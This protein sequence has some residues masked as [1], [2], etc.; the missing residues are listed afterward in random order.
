M[1]SKKKLVISLS[2]AAAVLV[3]AVIAI[4]AVFA[5]AQQT[6]QSSVNVSFRAKNVDCSVVASYQRYTDTEEQ[7]IGSATFTAAETTTEKEV[8]LAP[9][10]P[11]V[12]DDQ[13]SESKPNVYV[14]LIYKITKTSS[15]N[16]V[17]ALK[18]SSYEGL[19]VQFKYDN[20]SFGDSFET[21]TIS[22]AT[23]HTI[24]VR[25]T[26]TETTLNSA[27]DVDFSINLVWDL[28]AAYAA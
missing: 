10:K 1:S 24:T 19:N 5:A 12:L 4:V 27:N 16:L 9:E 18:S 23:A 21:K 11:I 28:S 14:D 15:S 8:S 6:V 3:A 25:A 26:L 22:D 13:R 2:V 17:V 7:S 20:G